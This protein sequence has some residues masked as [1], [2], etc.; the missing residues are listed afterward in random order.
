[1]CLGTWKM[2]SHI[3]EEM[4]KLLLHEVCTLTFQKVGVILTTTLL[5]CLGIIGGR[6]K[7][8]ETNKFAI[9]VLCVAHSLNLVGRSAVDCNQEAVNFFSTFQLFYTF[10]SASTTQWKILKCCIGNESVLKSL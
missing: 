8:L 7:L 9:Y 5:T 3:G 4:V 2:D 10:F 6:R 1:M